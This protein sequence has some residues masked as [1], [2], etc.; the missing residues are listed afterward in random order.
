[1]IFNHFDSAPLC[2]LVNTASRFLIKVANLTP[3][4]RYR[5]CRQ[6]VRSGGGSDA[7][8]VV[9]GI[10]AATLTELRDAGFKVYQAHAGSIADNLERLARKN[11][12]E[13]TADRMAPGTGPSHDTDN[14]DLPRFGCGF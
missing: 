9:D 1:M 4:D 5:L 7:A 3:Q 10:G 8:F 12:P 11:L 13:L 2:L 14:D 6:I